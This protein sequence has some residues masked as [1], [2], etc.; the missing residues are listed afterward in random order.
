MIYKK[1]VIQMTFDEVWN[2]ILNEMPRSKRIKIR[3]LSFVEVA[4]IEVSYFLRKVLKGG[5]R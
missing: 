4:K 2:E 5:N 1:E 3:F